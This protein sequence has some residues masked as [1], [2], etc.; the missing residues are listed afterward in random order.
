MRVK[1]RGGLRLFRWNGCQAISYCLMI[2]S[3]VCLVFGFVFIQSWEDYAV[4]QSLGKE[5]YPVDPSVLRAESQG[6][7]TSTQT[8][9]HSWSNGHPMATMR[10]FEPLPKIGNPALIIVA[11]NRKE[12]LVPTLKSV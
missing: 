3:T 11:H 10:S 1:V 5:E 6:Q 12:Y 2:F 4:S 9:S 7:L 8:P